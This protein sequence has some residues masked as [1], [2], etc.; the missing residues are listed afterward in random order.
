[1][2]YIKINNKKIKLT[3]QQVKEIQQ[4]FNLADIKLSDIPVGDTFKVGEYEFIVLEHAKETTAVILKS[5]LYTN[6]KFGNSNNYN[7]C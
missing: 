1:M 4:S 2:D 3:P 6:Q 5:L 7:G